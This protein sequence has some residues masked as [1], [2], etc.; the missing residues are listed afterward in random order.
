MLPISATDQL[1]ILMLSF[2]PVYVLWKS[3]AIKKHIHAEPI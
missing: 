2:I 3:A 1:S